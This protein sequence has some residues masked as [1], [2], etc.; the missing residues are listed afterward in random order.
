VSLDD[1]PEYLTA[2]DLEALGIT[3]KDIRRLN[4]QPVEYTAL[5][6]RPCW[7]R[8]E[9]AELLGEGDG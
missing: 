3:V 4:P 7:R 6:G 2:D 9:L 5:D 8:D 1:L